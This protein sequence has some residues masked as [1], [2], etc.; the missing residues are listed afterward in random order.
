MTVAP[1]PAA[2]R[3]SPSPPAARRNTSATPARG[4]QSSC[5]R[6]QRLAPAHRRHRKPQPSP[7]PFKTPSVARLPTPRS[8]A[9]RDPQIPIGALAKRSP[10]LPAVSSLGGFRAPAPG[11]VPPSQRAGAR[12][13]SPSASLRFF[14]RWA[15][16]CHSNA[17]GA[18]AGWCSVLASGRSSSPVWLSAPWPGRSA[19]PRSR[20][21]RSAPR[22]ACPRLRSIGVG[23][24]FR[25]PLPPNRTGGFPAYGSPVGGFFIETV[26]RI[27]RPCEARTARLPRR[28]HLASVDGRR[29][30]CP[31]RGAFPAC[32][33]R[34]AAAS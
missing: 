9:V 28:R 16:N 21:R 5:D 4:R 13:P 30:R 31:D 24:G 11:A 15:S 26:S 3:R 27:T 33:G 19:S 20:R 17:C 18:C 7:L 12:N 34:R 1:H 6:G 32:A 23:I 29:G 25:R 22:S 8:P 14:S 2:H 10:Y